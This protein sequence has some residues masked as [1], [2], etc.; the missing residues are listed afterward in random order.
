MHLTYVILSTPA[1]SPLMVVLKKFSWLTMSV[2]AC[3]LAHNPTRGLWFV[4]LQSP[5]LRFIPFHSMNSSSGPV[6][7][8]F[9]RNSLQCYEPR[10]RCL[11]LYSPIIWLI[12]N[13]FRDHYI[14]FSQAKN[15]TF[16]LQR[17]RYIS[18]ASTRSSSFVRYSKRHDRA[19]QL[20]LPC[21][22][23]TNLPS[24]PRACHR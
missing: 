21:L 24:H 11:V 5:C 6:C 13:N 1:G 9:I 17:V 2:Y 12:K 15:S 3:T 18:N 10:F 19:S 14:E 16:D 22:S 4:G 8:L 7:V 20:T 23:G